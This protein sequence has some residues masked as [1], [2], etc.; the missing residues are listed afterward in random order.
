M[1]HEEHL[2]LHDPGRKLPQVP[3]PSSERPVDKDTDFTPTSSTH[4]TESTDAIT[5]YLTVD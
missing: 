5:N 3:Y 1:H 4:T 2:H